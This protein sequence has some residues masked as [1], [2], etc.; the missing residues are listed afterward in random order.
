MVVGQVHPRPRGVVIGAVLVLARVI[1]ARRGSAAA[2]S[3]ARKPRAGFPGVPGVSSES[4]CER[5]HFDSRIPSVEF[6]MKYN[7]IPLGALYIIAGNST[8][9]ITFMIFC[10]CS[11]SGES[12]PVL[13]GVRYFCWTKNTTPRISGRML[14]ASI[15]PSIG[16]VKSERPK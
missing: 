15:G 7:A 12:V 14:N 11:C 2:R 16:I 4:T 8:T 9:I 1:G 10:C 5:I 3:R 6:T 13:G